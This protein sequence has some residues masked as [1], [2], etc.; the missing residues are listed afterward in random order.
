MADTKLSALPAL[1]VEMDDTDEIY[2]NDGGSSKKQ[3]YSVLKAA[4]ATAAQGAT[5]DSAF[6]LASTAAQPA[7][8]KKYVGQNLQTGTSYELVLGD[9]GKIIEMNNAGANT[10]NIPANASVAFPVDT[11]IDVIQYGAG[12]TTITI[13]TDTLTGEVVSTGQY[14]AMSLWKRAATEWVVIGGTT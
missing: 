13:T 11:R 12:T 5:A 14:K 9:A 8:L 10:L 7:D 3:A 4:F 6:A 1:A 2:L